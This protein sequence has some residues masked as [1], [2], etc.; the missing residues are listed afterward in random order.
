MSGERGGITREPIITLGRAM[1]DALAAIV[2][3][4]PAPDKAID[5]TLVDDLREAVARGV[6]IWTHLELFVGEDRVIINGVEIPLGPLEVERVE[7]LHGALAR[8][9]FGGIG[10]DRAVGLDLLE[11]YVSRCLGPP[12]TADGDRAALRAAL[13]EFSRAGIRTLGSK[14]PDPAGAGDQHSHMRSFAAGAYVRALNVFQLITA[15]LKSGTRVPS[16]EEWRTVIDDLVTVAMHRPNYLLRLQLVACGQ[17]RALEAKGIGYAPTH[18]ANTSSY[19]AAIGLVIGLDRRTL[20]DLASCAF[21]ADLGFALL[22]QTVLD[23]D[24]ELADEE[25]A[26]LRQAS[27]RS[28]ASVLGRS[29]LSEAFLRRLVVALEHHGVLA[30]EN[31]RSAKQLHLYSRIIAASDAF[32]ALT[33]ERSWRPALS[34]GDA[35]KTLEREAESGAK[36]DSTVVRALGAHL[37]LVA[38]L[39]AAARR[40]AD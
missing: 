29:Q 23:R 39:G 12:V 10:F 9:G 33:S 34:F 25:L 30:R 15:A 11:R 31:A 36:Y 24:V 7:W 32:D 16:P 6:R 28:F 14:A 35:L 13:A 27:L 5:R 18:A 22:P 8:R 38:D 4:S 17:R 1:L 26:E 3:A 2:G 21:F 37:R 40:A 19:A 20:I